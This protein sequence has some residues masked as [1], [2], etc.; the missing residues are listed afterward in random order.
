M[1]LDVHI[2][3]IKNAKAAL[4]VGQ[5]TAEALVLQ[6]LDAISKYHSLNAIAELGLEQALKTARE[7][8]REQAAGVRRG[9]L[10]GIPITVKDLFEVQGFST[11]AGTRTQ[12]EAR[13]TSTAVARLQDAGAVIIAKT[14][15]HEIALG[16]TGENE[17][18]GDVKNPHDAERQSGG[19]SSGSAVAVAVGAGLA[20]LGTD[21]GG[22]IRVPA[23]LCG[24]TGFKP[25]HGLV[26]LDGALPLSPTCDHAGPLANNV[27]DARL[28]TEVL[29]RRELPFFA[30]HEPRFGVPRSYLEGRLTT[31][32]R[33]AF[34]AMLDRLETAG[35]VLT[36]IVVPD[37]ELTHQAYT[38]LVRAE[39]A[40]VHQSALAVSPED[41]SLPVRKALEAGAAMLVPEYLEA[42]AQR[43][44]VIEGLRQA[45]EAQALDAL[46]LPTTPSPALRR[47]ET[48]V[49][50]ESG[51]AL[52]RDAQLDLTAPFSMAGMP[53]AA[54]PFGSID[55]LPVGIQVVTHWRKDALALNLASWTERRLGERQ[56]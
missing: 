55:G 38:P 45:F 9:P 23:A 39:A 1:G 14:N 10:H 32:M 54:I 13:G 22:S 11:R 52:Y 35:A 44:R 17:W 4:D 28:V 49:N 43:R 33:E 51:S 20:S 21:T 6:A 5:V 15:M 2:L 34:D 26:P 25:T 27:A 30:L 18:T 41:F 46:I 24:I 29:T 12:L 56:D 16:L 50:L 53:V 3:T 40:H 37:L 48:V 7:R 36:S 19:S 42:R 8:D 31:E 47:G